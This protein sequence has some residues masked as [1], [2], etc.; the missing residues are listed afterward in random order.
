LCGVLAGPVFVVLS[1]ILG[2]F[3]ARYDWQRHAVSSLALTRFIIIGFA[4]MC[5]LALH[6]RRRPA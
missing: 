3:G 1:P 6:L 4:W 2:A 5:F